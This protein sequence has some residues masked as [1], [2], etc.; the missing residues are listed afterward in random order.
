MLSCLY[1]N[2]YYSYIKR[3]GVADLDLQLRDCSSNWPFWTWRK[4]LR[5]HFESYSKPIKNTY[6]H[7]ESFTKPLR[8][9]L[10][11]YL[12]LQFTSFFSDFFV[13]AYKAATQTTSHAIFWKFCFCRP[14]KRKK[15][16]EILFFV[17]K[18]LIS[19]I[20][21]PEFE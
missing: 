19:L 20:N 17:E 18:A 1:L 7:T 9:R 21:A 2:S 4:S 13:S 10:I 15:N 14:K 3:V 6:A 5:D 12:V 8:E 11:N 16:S